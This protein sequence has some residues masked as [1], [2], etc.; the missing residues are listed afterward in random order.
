MR[1]AKEW[2]HAFFYT[3]K[4]MKNKFF[5]FMG[6]AMLAMLCFTFSS[7]GDDDD[8]KGDGNTN[9]NANTGLSGYY[10][11]IDEEC[12]VTWD[13]PYKYLGRDCAF[14][15]LPESWIFKLFIHFI[16]NNK[17][18]TGYLR[19]YNKPQQ[20]AVFTKS[21]NGTTYYFVVDVDRSAVYSYTISNGTTIYIT[22]GSVCTIHDGCIYDDGGGK[23][24]KMK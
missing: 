19:V 11:Q 17:V 22:S 21:Y 15:D 23:Y 2:L 20:N 9:T 8:E 6:I 14:E 10:A 18:E 16:D 7:C 12:F 24:Y 13:D 5:K 1:Q 4:T 3:L